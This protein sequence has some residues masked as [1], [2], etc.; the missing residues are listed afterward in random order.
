MERRTNPSHIIQA[1]STLAKHPFYPITNCNDMYLV[2][3]G[4][5]GKF[6]LFKQS[7]DTL[8]AVEGPIVTCGA[9]HEAF[10]F[11]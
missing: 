5:I 2:L 6:Y 9:L 3:I 1:H 4:D 10:L 7:V 8:F 11:I